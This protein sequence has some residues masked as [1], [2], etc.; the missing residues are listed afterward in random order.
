MIFEQ[1][2]LRT[3][4]R[5]EYSNSSFRVNVHRRDHS[6]FTNPSVAAPIILLLSTTYIPTRTQ[7]TTC[8]LLCYTYGG[9]TNHTSTFDFLLYHQ[10]YKR[11]MEDAKLQALHDSLA[12]LRGHKGLGSRGAYSWQ[13]NTDQKGPVD[14][15]LPANALYANFVPSGT[16]D[17]NAKHA[18][19]GDGREIK[20]DFSDIQSCSDSSA[21][22]AT[23]KRK[24]KEKKKAEKLAA[25]KKAKLLAKMQAKKAAKKAKKEKKEKSASSAIAAPSSENAKQSKKRKRKEEDKKEKKKVKLETPE[26]KSKTKKKSKKEKSKSSDTNQVP[27]ETTASKSAKAKS[28]KTSRK[29]KRKAE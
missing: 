2:P 1:L 8:L 21:D 12:K 19:D 20:R 25:K 27:G 28:E 23:K 4:D 22:E 26:S 24:R 15:G 9:T 29:K 11:T 10:Y 6:F 3:K 14:F 7:R 13:K 5:P 16:Y 18:N 17:P